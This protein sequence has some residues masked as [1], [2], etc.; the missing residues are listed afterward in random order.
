MEQ[1][2]VPDEV[3]NRIVVLEHK[4]HNL[5]LSQD[6]ENELEDLYDEWEY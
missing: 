4:Y 1:R 3:H 6:E 5:G 2:Q